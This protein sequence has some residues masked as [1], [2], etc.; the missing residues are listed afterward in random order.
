MQQLKEL[1]STSCSQ[2]ESV[3]GC[4]LRLLPCMSRTRELLKSGAIGKVVR[5]NMQVGQW[6]PSWRP[7]SMVVEAV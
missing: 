7:V 5:T 1:I 4:N 6:Q 2:M 3:V